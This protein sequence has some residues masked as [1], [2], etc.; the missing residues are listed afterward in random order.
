MRIWRTGEARHYRDPDI[1]AGINMAIDRHSAT[2]RYKE[3]QRRHFIRAGY[4][5]RPEFTTT[6]GYVGRHH[7]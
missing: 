2:R 7:A 4:L 1:E 5:P 6:V 3:M